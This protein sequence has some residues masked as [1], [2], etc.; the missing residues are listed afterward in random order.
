[1]ELDQ[2]R[3]IIAPVIS[4]QG[5]ELVD[6]ELKGAPGRRFLRIIVDTE[7]GIQVGQCSE[8]SRLLS[9]LLDT[10]NPIDGRYTLEVT[11]PGIDRPLRTERDFRR[12]LGRL[13]AVEYQAP[14][15]P[16]RCQVNGK[17]IAV[18]ENSITVESGKELVTIVLS[19][20]GKA[21]VVL[22]W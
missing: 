5:I 3:K 22:P 12:N 2:L 17:I 10:E 18:T 7:S 20:I 8:L 4:D 1:M 9:D 15:S 14:E 6:M 21:K 16:E 13:I 11:S 19:H